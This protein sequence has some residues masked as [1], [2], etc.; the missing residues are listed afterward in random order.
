MQEFN[1]WHTQN[2][3]FAEKRDPALEPAGRES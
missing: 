2:S 3:T 1:A